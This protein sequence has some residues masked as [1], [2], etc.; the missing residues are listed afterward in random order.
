MFRF[1]AN[2]SPVNAGLIFGFIIGLMVAGG[3]GGMSAWVCS[4]IRTCP[5]SW[6]PFVLVSSIIFLIVFLI[7][8]VATIVF[9]RL[10]RI[11]D[12]STGSG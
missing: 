11:L 7:V 2:K 4:G 9:V 5:A 1:I 10:Y 3:Y 6:E 8:F 12:T